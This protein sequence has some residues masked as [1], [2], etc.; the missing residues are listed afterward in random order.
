MI[1]VDKRPEEVAGLSA[2]EWSE[3]FITSGHTFQVG[4]APADAFQLPEVAG[5]AVKV[6]L[7]DGEKCERC[8]RVLPDVGKHADHPTLCGRCDDAVAHLPAAAQ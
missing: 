1:F 3:I 7:A 6:E 2:D 5:I 4:A 8:W